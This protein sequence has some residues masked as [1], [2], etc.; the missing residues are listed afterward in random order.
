M[1][2]FNVAT[3]P[4]VSDYDYIENFQSTVDFSIDDNLLAILGED[5][6]GIDTNPSNGEFSFDVNCEVSQGNTVTETK[7]MTINVKRKHDNGQLKGSLIGVIIGV[8]LAGIL[9]IIA[10][11]LLVFAKATSR[12]CFTD[13]DEPNTKPSRGPG[14]RSRMA[15]YQQAQRRRQWEEGIF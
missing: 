2:H 13:D 14:L 9:L 7:K 6:Y 12:W 8:V 4:I 10:V 11:A 15:G 5:G 3:N 1:G